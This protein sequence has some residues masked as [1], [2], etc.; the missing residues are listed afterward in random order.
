MFQ[1]IDVCNV[2]CYSSSEIC[3]CGAILEKF[4]L[5]VRLHENL[6]DLEEK[7]LTLMILYGWFENSVS[8]RTKSFKF[9]PPFTCAPFTE[10]FSTWMVLFCSLPLSMM[11][12]L[13]VVTEVLWSKFNRSTS[14]LK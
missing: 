1:V 4:E 5:D 10:A 12:L 2:D 14:N 9:E 11:L 6:R 13:V 8:I 7:M 3:T